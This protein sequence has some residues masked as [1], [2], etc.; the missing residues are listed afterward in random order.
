MERPF[1]IAANAKIQEI[2]MINN[3]DT[4]QMMLSRGIIKIA[5]QPRPSVLKLGSRSGE[6]VYAAMVEATIQPRIPITA[7]TPLFST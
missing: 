4:R 5:A 7:A 3:M 1:T 6:Q 2:N